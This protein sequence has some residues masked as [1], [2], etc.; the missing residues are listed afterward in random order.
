MRGGFV[1]GG[2]SGD[3]VIAFGG[4]GGAGVDD[5]DLGGCWVGGRESDVDGGDHDV[6]DEVGVLEVARFEVEE[7]V[8]PDGGDGTV[9]DQ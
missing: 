8:Y 9:M 4:E 2:E 1:G 7:R 5:V 3:V 6:G